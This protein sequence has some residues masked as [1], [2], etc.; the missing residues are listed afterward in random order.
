[1]DTSLTNHGDDQWGE[2][3]VAFLRLG[4][5]LEAPGPGV[6]EH[7]PP[8]LQFVGRDLAL[9]RDRIEGLTAEQ[10]KHQLRLALHAP[11]LGELHPL[12]GHRLPGGRWRCLPFLLPHIG[13]L[14]HH[15]D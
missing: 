1:M 12:A 5:R 9:A 13:L 7:A 15:H 4:A 14:G 2:G 10:A 8:A 3:Q 11:P 6:Q